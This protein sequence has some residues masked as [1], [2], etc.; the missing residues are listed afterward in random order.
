M[1]AAEQPR[2]RSIDPALDR[3]LD[4]RR[5]EMA[6][7]HARARA[8]E[9]TVTPYHT[10]HHRTDRQRDQRRLVGKLANQLQRAHDHMVVPFG[11]RMARLDVDALQLVRQRLARPALAHSSPSMGAHEQPAG[12]WQA[13][14]AL[15]AGATGGYSPAP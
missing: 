9:A 8:C 12:G 14:S 11:C 4:R 5:R 2:P 3:C 13:P 7:Q 10:G 1:V 15:G 6:C